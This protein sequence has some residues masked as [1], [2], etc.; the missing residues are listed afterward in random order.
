ML[1]WSGEVTASYHYQPGEANL[2]VIDPSGRIVLKVIGGV[3]HAKLQRVLT[4]L[5]GLLACQRSA[6]NDKME[7][8]QSPT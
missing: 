1:D 4:A 7:G 8:T 6:P 2:F 3:S 5:G